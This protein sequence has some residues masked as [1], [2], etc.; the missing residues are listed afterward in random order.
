[1]DASGWDA[2]HADAQLVWSRGP[3]GFVEADLTTGP[4]LVP[5]TVDDLD[6]NGLQVTRAAEVVRRVETDDGP[7]YA[8]DLVVRARRPGEDPAGS[9]SERL[10][11]VPDARR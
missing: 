3:N 11:S 2:R 10:A 5:S 4:Q 8:I 9:G 1:V 6:G 7:R